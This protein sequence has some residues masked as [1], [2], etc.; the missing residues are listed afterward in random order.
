MRVQTYTNKY[1]HERGF[2][3]IETLVAVLILLLV[4]IGPMTIAQ[5]GL[6]RA[7]FANERITAVYLAQEGVE[8]V[9]KLRDDN[10]LE[11]Y[12]GSSA[13]TWDWYTN[14]PADCRNASVGC[15]VDIISGSLSPSSFHSCQTASNCI[16]Q[17]NTAVGSGDYAYGYPSISTGW[18]NSPYT[19]KIFVL[20]QEA[21]EEV[22]VRTEVSWTSNLFTDTTRKVILETKLFNTYENIN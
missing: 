9:I 15:D 8:S 6:Q 13:D 2:T 22:R 4:M 10:A 16:L 5:Q 17:E 14:L 1:T 11:F 21:D 12:A 18:I 19:R 3:L 20:T 7:Y